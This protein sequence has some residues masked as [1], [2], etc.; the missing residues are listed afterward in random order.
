LF[1]YL[2]RDL[3]DKEEIAQIWKVL[4]DPEGI[5]KHAYEVIN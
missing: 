1:K 2:F 3:L 5:L 4:N